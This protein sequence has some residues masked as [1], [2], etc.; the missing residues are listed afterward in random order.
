MDAHVELSQA[1]STLADA[2]YRVMKDHF[3]PSGSHPALEL[4]SGPQYNTWIEMPFYP[5]QE[6]VMEYVDSILEAGLPA[7]TLFIDD[8]WAPDYGDWIFDTRRFPDPEGM[9]R[10]LH[11]RG[12]HVVLWLVPF[13]SPDSE[14]FRSLEKSGLL[15]RDRDGNT[16]IRRWW[17]GFSAILDITNPQ[18]QT[19]LRKKLDALQAIGVDGFKYDAGDI[20]FYQPGDLSYAQAT[21]VEHSQTWA[22]FGTHTPFN[23]YRA[24]WKMGGQPLGQR[25]HDKPAEWGAFGIESLVPEVLGQAMIGHYYTCPDMIGG[26]E[27]NSC[28]SQ[29]QVDQEFVVR[30]AQVAALMPMMQFSM[31]PARILDSQHLQMVRD[32]LQLRAKFTPLILDLAKAAAQT[33]VPIVRPMSFHCSDPQAAGINDQ[34]FLG[35]DVVVAPQVKQG[36]TTREVFLPHG[37]WLSDREE[38]IQVEEDGQCFDVPTPLDRLPHFTRQR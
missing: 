8:N 38:M 29:S 23:E 32:L 9:L 7:G 30:Y 15:L 13:V 14:Q 20:G 25:L 26:G 37:T 31:N 11:A 6:K 22:E 18:A 36:A 4:L 33:G 34:F 5:T 21:P 24:C 1:G 17:N 10:D 28:S 3:P 35:E 27:V 2:Y 16:A 19:W 12:F